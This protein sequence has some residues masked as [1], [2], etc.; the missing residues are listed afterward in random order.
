MRDFFIGIF[1]KPTRSYSF[2]FIKVDTMQ[3]MEVFQ[4]KIA[5][6]SIIFTVRVYRTEKLMM[7]PCS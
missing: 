7:F 3:Y 5:L 2:F 6:L 1:P 4:K